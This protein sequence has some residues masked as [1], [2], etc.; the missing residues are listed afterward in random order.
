MAEEQESGTDT[1]RGDDRGRTDVAAPPARAVGDDPRSYLDRLG[2][3]ERL[4][5]IGEWLTELNTARNI[6][7]SLGLTRLD[8]AI[9]HLGILYDALKAAEEEIAEAQEHCCV[10]GHCEHG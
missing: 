3:A 6:V 7:G 9:A 10:R 4:A 5:Q 1:D 8:D 2:V